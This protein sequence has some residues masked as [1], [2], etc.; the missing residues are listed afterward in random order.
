ME[1]QVEVV[2]L[3]VLPLWNDHDNVLGRLKPKRKISIF[4]IS[5]YPT[6]PPITL[7]TLLHNNNKPNPYIPI[8]TK[9]IELS[10]FL[11]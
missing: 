9:I 3:I 2:A 8:I 6:N 7:L 5:I 1:C 11:H 10:I 4:T